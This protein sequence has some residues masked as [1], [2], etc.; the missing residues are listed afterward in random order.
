M[1]TIQITSRMI[2]AGVAELVFDPELIKSDL[3][4]DILCAALEAGGY[5]V[6]QGEMSL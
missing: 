6:L 1:K 4:E 2:E 5:K 3:I